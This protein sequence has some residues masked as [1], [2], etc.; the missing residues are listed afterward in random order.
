M[1][2]AR[3]HAL[4][5]AGSGVVSGASRPNTKGSGPTS[6][7]TLIGDFDRDWR[8]AELALRR[9]EVNVALKPSYAMAQ[10]WLGAVLRFSG[11]VPE[12]L[13]VARLAKELRS[14]GVVRWSA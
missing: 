6:W 10:S 9:G 12:A 14:A 1:L 3:Y 11:R 13:E 2:A 5:G 8:K 7:G 4:D